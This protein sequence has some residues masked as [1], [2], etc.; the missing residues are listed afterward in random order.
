MKFMN[1]SGK[2]NNLHDDEKDLCCISIPF[3][4]NPFG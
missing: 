4:G 1:I 2:G 3:G